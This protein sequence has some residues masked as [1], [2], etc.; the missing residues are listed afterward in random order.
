MEGT[1]KRK[2]V[3]DVELS[4]HHH[5]ACAFLAL[6]YPEA[7]ARERKDWIL[8]AAEQRNNPQLGI[9]DTALLL[10]VFIAASKEKCVLLPTVAVHITV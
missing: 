3:H 5:P 6:L 10:I 9:L 1:F 2:A 7:A 8:V 4:K